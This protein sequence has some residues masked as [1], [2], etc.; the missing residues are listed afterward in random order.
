VSPNISLTAQLSHPV[1]YPM[2][3]LGVPEK[4]NFTLAIVWS[5]ILWL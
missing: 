5:I 1:D 2:M 3:L 4:E